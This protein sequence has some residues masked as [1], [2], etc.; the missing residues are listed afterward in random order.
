MINNGKF[1]LAPTLFMN[2]QGQMEEYAGEIYWRM[3]MDGVT[4]PSEVAHPLP[5]LR[6]D[7]QAQRVPPS[8]RPPG[9]RALQDP[10]EPDLVSQNVCGCLF[11]CDV[12][13][14]REDPTEA[15]LVHAA[16]AALDAEPPTPTS[17]RTATTT[18]STT[19]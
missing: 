16:E 6:H 7:V 4:T 17:T 18:T 9:D 14:G 11:G 13:C 5:R 15:P 19:S 1:M 3:A 10:E 2:A 8:P 12:C